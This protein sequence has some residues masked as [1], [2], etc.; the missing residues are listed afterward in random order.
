ML[1][2]S[3]RYRR[4]EVVDEVVSIKPKFL[5]RPKNVLAKESQQAHFEAKLEPVTDANLRVEWYKDGRPITVGSRFR[6]IHDFGYV[7]LD[8]VGL[9]P[10]DAG[11]Y[12]CRAENLNGADQ[13]DVELKV[14]GTKSILTGSQVETRTVEEIQML[15]Q[16]KTKRTSWEEEPVTTQAPVFTTSLKNVEIKEL[17]RAH[18]E[19]RLIPVSD[20]TMKVE[21]FKDG[22]PV[23][24]GMWEI[25]STELN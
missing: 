20:S 7:A 3:S 22:E 4:S 25:L 14:K 11:V 5:T 2:D 15:E 23:K 12:T 24:S 16:S 18:F 10:E 13:V 6:P 17:Q 8:I 9:I 19:S 21:W 1:E